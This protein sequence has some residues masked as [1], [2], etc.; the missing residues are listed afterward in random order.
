MVTCLNKL[1]CLVQE[2]SSLVLWIYWR[3]WSDI[4]ILLATWFS[5]W[6][7]RCPWC[8]HL[9]RMCEGGMVQKNREGVQI[10][11]F[12]G[13][14]WWWNLYIYIW[15]SISLIP[16]WFM[17]SLSLAWTDLKYIFLDFVCRKVLPFTM[18]KSMASSTFC[19]C[20][21]IRGG[22][23][24]LGMVLWCAGLLLIFLPCM[25]GI[26]EPYTASVLLM[27]SVVIRHFLM[28]FF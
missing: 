18:K 13:N 8:A 9:R 7:S 3:L 22:K 10:H 1:S 17:I 26:W 24:I 14:M 21:A 28:W 15:S 5:G 11:Y 23:G 20:L 19:W 12:H 27:S 16:I 2:I 6:I 4:H 25:M